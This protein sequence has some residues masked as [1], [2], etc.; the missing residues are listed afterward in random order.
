MYRFRSRQYRLRPYLMRPYRKRRCRSC[1]CRCSPCR[2]PSSPRS[3]HRP[4]GWSIHRRRRPSSRR[5]PCRPT[6]PKP[7]NR[8]GRSRASSSSSTG[9]PPKV[10]VS[11]W[12]P[13]RRGVVM[14]ARN[15]AA[16]FSRRNARPAGRSTDGRPRGDRV[17][18]EKSRKDHHSLQEAIQR[19]IGWTG[20]G[21]PTV[22]TDHV[23]CDANR[24]AMNAS[25][26][27]PYGRN[28]SMM[29]CSSLK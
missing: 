28:F 12:I 10:R 29:P 26:T 11:W 23:A 15:M 3:V 22:A 9:Q 1:L 27:R 24:S 16:E 18:W 21:Q 19:L 17:R 6:G 7:S 20:S 2:C 25:P 8:T 14:R 4:V 13:P 5:S